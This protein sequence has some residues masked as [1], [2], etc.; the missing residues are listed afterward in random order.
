MNV[1]ISDV[2]ALR[3]VD[4]LHL[5][6]G[7]AFLFMMKQWIVQSRCSNP[8]GYIVVDAS[9]PSVEHPMASADIKLWHRQGQLEF[10]LQSEFGLA[11]GVRDSLRR[12]LRAFNKE[13]RREIF[14]RLRFCQSVDDI[15]PGFPRS[16]RLQPFINGVAEDRNDDRCPDWRTVYRWWKIWVRAGRDPRALCPSRRRQG[17]RERRLEKYQIDAMNKAIDMHYLRRRRL[18]FSTAYKACCNYIIDHV[19]GADRARQLAE[20]QARLPPRQRRSIFPSQNAF[21]EECRRRSRAE[22]IAA[23]FGPQA[24]RNALFPVGEGPDVRFPMERVEA[25]FKFLRLFVVD[26]KSGFP[27]GTPYLMAAI[28][29]YSTCIVGFDVSFDPPS[30]VSV[31]RCLRH[32][33]SY[34]DMEIVRDPETGAALCRHPFPMNGVPQQLVLD[35]E[36]VFHSQALRESA[37]QIGTNLHFVPKGQPWQKGHIERFWHTVDQCFL[38]MF[39]GKVLRPSQKPGHDYDPA[40][41]AVVTLGMLKAV[42]TKAIVDTYHPADHPTFAGQSRAK[43]W[44]DAVRVRPPRPVRRHEDLVELVG[45]YDTRKAERRGIRF[46]GLRYNS[47]ELAEYRAGFEKDPWVEIRIDPDDIGSLWIVDRNLGI[48]LRIPC[49]RGEYAE[50]LSLHQHLVIQRRAKENTTERYI[51]MQELIIAKAELFALAETML[52]ERSVRG[53]RKR[54]AQFLGVGRQFID[55]LSKRHEDPKESAKFLDI[56]PDRDDDDW[57]VDP[58]DDVRAEQEA[59]RFKERFQDREKPKASGTQEVVGPAT[60]APAKDAAGPTIKALAAPAA[61]ISKSPAPEIP[62]QTPLDGEVPKLT[63]PAD[64]LPDRP[65]SSVA[66]QRSAPSQQASQTHAEERP[67]EGALKSRRPRREFGSMGISFDD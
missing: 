34:K 24:A 10:V 59:R 12:T 21:R 49:T 60:F 50:G 23:R 27:L 7:D 25:D 51:R 22:R 40:E 3:E 29:C 58:E 1:H 48:T 44:E 8:V 66:A 67:S 65:E 64:V 18:A 37:R 38:D 4:D 30:Y 5:T 35:N 2:S 28:D 14:R 16:E 46:K 47:P 15:G 19:G 17:N 36:A 13:E 56:S 20:E 42:L 63:H 61:P 39:P 62:V 45:R 55:I 57:V 26:E 31:G 43:V 9:A 53:T 52:K 6:Q 33:V 11:I 32:V 54:V 41:D